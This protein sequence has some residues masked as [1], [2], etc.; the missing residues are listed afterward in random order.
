MRS[1]AILSVVFGMLLAGPAFAADPVSKY[2][3]AQPKTSKTA[4][5]ISKNGRRIVF[6]RI[7]KGT[8]VQMVQVEFDEIEPEPT[9]SSLPKP[10]VDDDK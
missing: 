1:A 2:S 9:K 10:P 8:L 6:V 7:Q 5:S 4:N 3:K